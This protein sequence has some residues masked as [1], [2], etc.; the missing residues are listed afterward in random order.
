MLTLAMEIENKGYSMLWSLPERIR[1]MTASLNCDNLYEVRLRCG[2]PLALTL[3]GGTFYIT[4]KGRVTENYKEGYIVS[5]KDIQRGLE[6][7]TRSSVY[8]YENEMKSGYVTLQGGHRV[9]V[10]GDVVADGD[11]ISAV[12]NV[13]SLNYRFARE[14][15]GCADAYMDEI[16]TQKGINNTL[17]V[18]PPM[19]GKTTVLRDVARS[20]SIR[21]YRVSVVDERGEIAACSSGVPAFELGASC[22]VLSGASKAEGMLLMLRSMSPDV[23][24][25]DEMGG[26]EDFDA[27]KEIK[28]RGVKIITSLHGDGGEYPDFDKVIFLKGAGRCSKLQE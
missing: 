8:A 15:I 18:A 28:K 1:N 26:K 22:D 24:I 4:P 14:I 10:C 3:T 7:I 6:L 21:G 12:R 2:M 5:D 19:A 9:G 13:H 23:I 17:F 11:K 20:L 27:V 25:T 16:L